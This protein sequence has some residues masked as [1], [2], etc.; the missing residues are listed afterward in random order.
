MLIQETFE[1][2][3]FRAID[4]VV[5]ANEDEHL[6][7]ELEEFVITS[8]V[9]SHLLHLFDEY[10]NQ[11]AVGNGVW[12]SGFFGSGKSHLLKILAVALEDREVAGKKAMDYLL[13]KT[14]G[15]PALSAAM[16]QAREK[17]PSESVLFNIDS[18]APNAGH[19]DSG[20][21][22][23]A[24]I[25]AFNR[26]CGYFDGDQQHIA[27]L[28]FDLD[29][30]GKLGVFKECIEANCGKPWED[31]RKASLLYKRQITKSFDEALG[32]PE[33]TTEDAVKYYKDTYK[34]D[35]N[36][37]A[38]RVN[39][40]IEM[41]KQEYGK[42][43]RLNFFVDEVGQFIAQNTNLMVNLQSV[44]EE[45][46]SEC[47]GDSWVFVTSQEDMENVV[48]Q[49]KVNS[50]NDFT[51]IQA[52]F[53]IKMTLS[54]ADAKEVIRARLL[55]KKPKDAD[56]FYSLYDKYQ[57]DFGM[58]FD[59]T[60]GAKH[61]KQYEDRDDFLDTYPFVPYQFEVFM[62]S[63]RGLSDHSCFTGRHNST[64]ARSMLGVFQIVAKRICEQGANTEEGTLAPFDFMFEGLRN[65]LKSEV[66]AAISTA[67][68]NLD[69]EM[70][71]RLLKALLLVKYCDDFR[72]TPA[73]LRVL[74]YGAFTESTAKLNDEIKVALDDLESQL[75]VRHNGDIY[76][77]LTNDE[78]EV[79]RE[80]N[81]TVVPETEVRGTL[82]EMFKDIC[83]AGK[84]TYHNG[85]FSHAYSYNFQVDGETQ[86]LKKYDLTVNLVTAWM[87]ESE[88]E[89]MYPTPQKT[90]SIVLTN[91]NDF[92]LG[93]RKFKQTERYC[94]ISSGSSDIRAAII[95]DKQTANRK[96]Y[97]QLRN[98]LED[99]LTNATYNAGGVDVTD[100]VTG[101][102]K[103]AVESAAV[104]LV[105][106][107]YTGLQQVK[108][109]YSDKDVYSQ[110]LNA[111]QLFDTTLPEYCQTVL[112]RIKLLQG[113]VTVGGDGI[114]SLMAVFT[115][116][117]FGWPE[118][119]VRSAVACLYAA[120]KVEVRKG[121]AS[122]ENTDL[123]EALSKKR[124][125]DKLT[126]SCVEEVTPEE[127]SSLSKAF[128]E[129]SGMRPKQTEE[130][131]FLKS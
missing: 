111:Q 88:L 70:E 122:L 99:L 22:L 130:K 105:R 26:H 67:E 11:D 10:N 114:S 93:L 36:A 126:V 97:K 7:N 95:H 45:L 14:S 17:H 25:K 51:K 66:Y 60:D 83:G 106:R 41:R 127:L 103:D 72:A 35:I 28:E 37:F 86:G 3:I 123:A 56:A 33:G 85:A 119:A 121:G 27:K 96:L 9:E 31:V 4:P 59:F 84:V 76:E 74:V 82:G 125:L 94:N 53:N 120:G 52:R 55:A 110:C 77:Y 24:F 38:K 1:K 129:F 92:L 20:A 46:N 100:K 39:E 54:S 64:G 112:S 5:K 87:P 75:Y 8:E 48:G 49:M 68:D 21:L 12:I 81:N 116:N 13:P 43:F 98:Q 107:S 128:H 78:K 61:Y 32:N 47:N 104:E 73:N 91:Q 80:I 113:I 29:R 44:A 69:N 65:D 63:L 108:E 62:S 15:D 16:A 18:F 71:T 101:S 2:D 19:S 40:Y 58:L 34:P 90:L 57:Q 117:E 115:K 23:A 42:G 118:V 102:G 6:Q 131:T 30:E 89:T 109:N 79:E 50:A 124:D